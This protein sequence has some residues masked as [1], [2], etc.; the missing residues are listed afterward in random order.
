MTLM[1]A[2]MMELARAAKLIARGQWSPCFLKREWLGM[3]DSKRARA[4]T[5]VF[6]RCRSQVSSVFMVQLNRLIEFLGEEAS[7]DEQLLVGLIPVPRPQP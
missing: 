6:S 1:V 4:L 5:P 2:C 3:S 7:M